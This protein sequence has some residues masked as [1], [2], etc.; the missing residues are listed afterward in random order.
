[1]RSQIIGV[2]LGGTLSNIPQ[3]DANER[4]WKKYDAE[5]RRH[6]ADQQRSMHMRQKVRWRMNM[7]KLKKHRDEQRGKKT[8]SDYTTTTRSGGRHKRQNQ[9]HYMW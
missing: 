3:V 6:L 4:E 7:K 5:V 9:Q 1:M 2:E 8:K